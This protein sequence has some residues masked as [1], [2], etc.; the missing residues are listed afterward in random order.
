MALRLAALGL[1]AA[2]AELSLREVNA[3][4]FA[5]G[6]FDAIFDVRYCPGDT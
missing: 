3:T 1:Q 4:D 2:V 6:D 5:P